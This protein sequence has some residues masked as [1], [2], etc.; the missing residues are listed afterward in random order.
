MKSLKTVE[1]GGPM[2]PQAHDD[3]FNKVTVGPLRKEI[4]YIYFLAE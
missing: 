1:K 4:Q 3:V 2:P